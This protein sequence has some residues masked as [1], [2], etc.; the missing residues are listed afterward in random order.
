MENY[1]QLILSIG[2]GTPRQRFEFITSELARLEQARVFIKGLESTPDFVTLG[3]L[4]SVIS[5]N[6]NNIYRNEN[7]KSDLSGDY[8]G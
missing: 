6:F 4:R 8:L 2:K 3:E 1:E 7:I 5:A